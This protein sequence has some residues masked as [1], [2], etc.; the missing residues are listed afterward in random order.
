MMSIQRTNYSMNG[1]HDAKSTDSS[2]GDS[3][4]EQFAGKSA[5]TLMELLVVIAIIAILAG[6]LL[7]A[8]GR[9]KANARSIGCLNNLKQLGLSTSI[10]LNDS[11]GRLFPNHQD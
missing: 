2:K 10:Y 1:T 9:A 8:L 4:H 3:R 5:F 11:A 6:L 7:P